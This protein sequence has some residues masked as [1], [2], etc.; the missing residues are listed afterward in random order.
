MNLIFMGRMSLASLSSIE[1]YEYVFR[2][3]SNSTITNFFHPSQIKNPPP[4]F[5]RNFATFKLFSLFQMQEILNS[6]L[7]VPPDSLIEMP[8]L[9][10]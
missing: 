6:L 2:S 4:A 7:G 8:V 10:V 3:K 9:C 1:I 5:I